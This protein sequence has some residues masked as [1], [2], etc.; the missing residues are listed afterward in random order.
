MLWTGMFKKSDT[1]QNLFGV[2]TQLSEGL[3]TRLRS[4]W[5]HLFRV[6]ILPVL[7]E[8]EEQFSL[9]Y[10]KTG[11]PN[12]SVA[13]MLGLCLL[14]GF[15]NLSDQQALDAFGFDIRWR[16]ALD[17]TDEEAYLSRRSLVEFRRRLAAK[18]PEMNLIRG[19]FE[20]TSKKAIKKLD[21]STS[22]QRLDSTLVVSNIC[23]RGRA[24]LFTNTIG[25]FIKSLDK[26]RLLRVPEGIR[27]WWER[28][29]EGWFGLPQE[30]HKAKLEQLAQY[31]YQLIVIFE[32]DKEV[33]GSEQYQLLVRLFQE[34]CEIKK[35]PDSDPS[36]GDNKKIEIKKK[37]Q[38]EVLQSA[39]DPDASCGYK[40]RG[41]SAHITETCNN[42]KKSEII[43]DY[44]VHGAARSD[45]GKAPEI[46]DRL[47]GAGSKP[48]KIFADGGYPSA[49]S[50][51][52]VIERNIDFMAPVNRG[53][54]SDEIMGRDQFEFDEKGLVVKCPNGHKPVDH[55]ILS[56]NNKKDRSLHAVFN[57]GVCRKCRVLDK[58]PVR[59]PNHR[60]RGCNPRDTVGN[61]RLDIAPEL[62]LRDKMYSNQRTPEWKEQYSI[63]SGI[64]A[65][66][67][68]LKRSHGMG[69]LR[70]RRIVKV[71]FAV[72]CKVIACNIKR[73]AKALFVPV[74]VLQRFI[75]AILGCLFVFEIKHNK[76]GQKISMKGIV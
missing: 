20:K 9:L 40:G 68:E 69:K 50:A 24:D 15:D 42:S 70:V 25:L 38:G 32:N 59:A 3:R 21:L 11:R 43:T 33:T 5:A 46:L 30:Q 10:G 66:M 39:F 14:Q 65:T 28:D 36:K 23:A 71:R 8:S 47:E 29:P 27:Q 48:D 75:W 76:L 72:A 26:D 60:A 13:R 41:Y 4:S 44:E 67:S 37:T 61:F 22:Q 55:R 73:W 54:L 57:G 56:H 49:P 52:T 74:Q 45:M 31:A 35:G 63:R 16:Y 1:Q 18:D 17:V 64:E 2:A 58:C 19:I 7:F 34:Q 12:F 62:R 51:L 6:E 53:P